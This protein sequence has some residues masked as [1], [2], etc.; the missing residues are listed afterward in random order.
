V[1]QDSA[2]ERAAD[3][4]ARICA[5]GERASPG[6]PVGRVQLDRIGP[7]LE[8]PSAVLKGDLLVAIGAATVV[9]HV[10]GEPGVLRAALAEG[11]DSDL[12]ADVPKCGERLERKPTPRFELGT[13]SLRVK[14]STS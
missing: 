13:P 2:G 12:D 14:C 11:E 6:D 10:S 7:N 5:S 1:Q 3:R 9:R 8:V 4:L